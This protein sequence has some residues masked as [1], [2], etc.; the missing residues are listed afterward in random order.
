MTSAELAVV[1][2]GSWFNRAKPAL[3]R[4]EYEA[5]C[6]PTLAEVFSFLIDRPAT[7]Y[8]E[9]K[10]ERTSSANLLVQS[11]V[12]SVVE[13]NFRSRVVVVSFDHSA[14][15][16]IKSR[17][18]SIRTGALFEPPRRPSRSWRADKILK[19]ATD[20][21]VDEILPHRLLARPG[22]IERAN[23]RNLPVVVW[24]VDSPAWVTRAQTLGVHALIT[25]NPARMRAST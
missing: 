12:G 20:C 15:A 1:A 4:E 23:E 7:I 25:N 3:A 16:A 14:L 6:V 24:T 10:A 13:F 22:L 9:L 18:P 19:A 8:V 5:Q 17:D 11:V 21:G 2:C